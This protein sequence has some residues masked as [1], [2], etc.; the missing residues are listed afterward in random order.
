MADEW[1]VVRNGIVLK[2]LHP[3]YRSLLT[4]LNLF[5]E[6]VKLNVVKMPIEFILLQEFPM[7]SRCLDAAFMQQEDLIAGADGRDSVREEN[8]S[9]PGQDAGKGIVE[10]G[11]DVFFQRDQRLFNN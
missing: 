1:R 3:A 10:E 11:L 5:Y 8:H 9:P 7:R 4:G 6:L 2:L